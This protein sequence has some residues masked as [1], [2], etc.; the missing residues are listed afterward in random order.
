MAA[1]HF[2]TPGFLDLPDDVLF[3]IFSY[4]PLKVVLLAELLCQRLKQAV[5]NYLTTLKNLNFYHQLISEDIFKQW[6]LN[7]AVTADILSRLLQRCTMARSI[8]YIPTSPQTSHKEIVNAISSFGVTAIELI[9]NKD[10]FD[11]VR[12]EH[13]NMILNEVY[14]SSTRS[15][16]VRSSLTRFSTLKATNVMHMEDVKVDLSLLAYCSKYSELSFVRCSFEVQSGSEMKSIAFPNLCKFLYTEQ[17]GRSASKQF[18]MMLVKKAAESEKLITMCLGL[19]DFAALETVLLNWKATNLEVL[20]VVS[21]GSYSASLQQLKYASIVADVCR[22]CRSSIQTI[23][24]PSSILIKRFFSQ[25]I[26]NGLHFGKLQTLQM[27]GLADTKMFLSPGNLVETLFYQEFLKLCPVISTLSLHSYTGSL[28]SLILPFTLTELVLPWDNRLNLEKQKNETLICLSANPQLKSLSILGVEEVDALLQ[29][30]V[31]SSVHARHL[32]TLEI[33]MESLEVFRLKNVCIQSLNLTGCANLTSFSIQCC[34]TLND[35]IVPVE[36][37]TSVTIYD[38][39]IG[40]ISRFV[41]HFMTAR[42]EHSFTSACHIH[43]QLH[44]VVKQEPD[45]KVEHTSNGSKLFSAVEKACRN[46]GN[47]LDFLILKDKLMHLFEH[48]SGEAMFPFTEFQAE[49][50]YLSGRFEAEMRTE[51]NRRQCILEGINRWK[52]CILDVKSAITT[53]HNAG[54]SSETLELAYCGSPFQCATNMQYFMRLNALPYLCQPSGCK[55]EMLTLNI[56]RIRPSIII[57]DE[58]LKRQIPNLQISKVNP[59]ILVSIV[60]YAHNIYTLF[61]YD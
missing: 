5:S 42:A 44:S 16:L 32:P 7:V 9:D 4:L 8:T 57:T 35:L 28:I 46:S 12:G 24:L 40:Y 2:H 55:S 47:S 45:A 11:K 13:P 6:D 26:T 20:E 21:T 25:L 48:N 49:D 3:Q 43:I 50:Q 36:S 54:N 17:P 52:N 37:L 15:I 27:T 23:T 19:S 53:S 22:Q 56:P 61:Y 10:F 14:L 41:D 60:E 38:G 58:I 34:P 1:Q 18:G 59:L 30:Y 39:Y 29:E 33:S 31:G 51:S